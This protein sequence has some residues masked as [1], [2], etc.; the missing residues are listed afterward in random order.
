MTK[1]LISKYKGFNANI[2]K[3]LASCL[4]AIHEEI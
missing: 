4:I 2:R 1:L 3:L